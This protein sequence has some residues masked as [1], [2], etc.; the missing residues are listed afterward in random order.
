MPDLVQIKNPKTGRY[1]LVDR[2]EGRIVESRE[3]PGPYPGVPVARKRTIKNPAQ[4]G[5][6]TIEQA[7][8]AVRAVSRDR[9]FDEAAYEAGRE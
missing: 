3:E 5:R 6:I 4:V 2:D 9:G 1:V 7:R 8:E